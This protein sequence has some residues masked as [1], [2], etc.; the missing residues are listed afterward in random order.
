MNSNYFYRGFNPYYRYAYQNRYFNP[1]QYSNYN[2]QCETIENKT[3]E[4][5]DDEYKKIDNDDSKREENKERVFKFGPIRIVDNKISG[6]GYSFAIDD[7]IIVA[8]IVFLL[9]ESKCDYA[10]LIVLGLM[11]F[12]IS[13]SSLNFSF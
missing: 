13:F 6:F 1:A 5:K 8:L 3:N 10:L 9:F 11:L 7:L 4:I 2:K 12:N